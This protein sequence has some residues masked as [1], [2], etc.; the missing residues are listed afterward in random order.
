MNTYAYRS[1]TD[2]YKSIHYCKAMRHS[3]SQYCTLSARTQLLYVHKVIYR[4]TK[5]SVP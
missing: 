5:Y 2:I 4:I 3:I 1:I